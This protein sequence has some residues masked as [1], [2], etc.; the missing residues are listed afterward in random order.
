[1][2]AFKTFYFEQSGAGASPGG[3]FQG[4]APLWVGLVGYKELEGS[5]SALTQQG[6]SKTLLCKF[7][8]QSVNYL[9][10]RIKQGMANLSH[11]N[12]VCLGL[13]VQF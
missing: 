5:R 3:N 11:F 10:V 6:L 9:I 8:S 7:D 12:R 13:S 2:R 1:M 4:A